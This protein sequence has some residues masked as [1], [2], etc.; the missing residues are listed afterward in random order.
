MVARL[1]GHGHVGIPFWHR[2]RQD[3]GPFSLASA[4][5]VVAS[6]PSPAW[7]G[8]GARGPLRHSRLLTSGWESS[9]ISLIPDRPT[10]R[11]LEK[12]LNDFKPQTGFLI[13]RS[14]VRIP[15]RSPIKSNRYMR[16]IYHGTKL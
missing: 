4:R 13:R 14:W 1:K 3:V 15:S 5:P 6:V 9:H 10:L 2:L 12:F 8:G 11:R 16:C 7:F